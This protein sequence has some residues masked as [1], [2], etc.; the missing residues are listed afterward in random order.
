MT[1]GEVETTAVAVA[2]I[3]NAVRVS[4]IPQLQRSCWFVVWLFCVTVG[5]VN[6][7]HDKN[8]GMYREGEGQ[9]PT[10]FINTCDHDLSRRLL[11]AYDIAPT[12]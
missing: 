1:R 9:I 8:E 4:Y 5:L 11:V 3:L 10:V 7:T 12:D 6:P 2:S